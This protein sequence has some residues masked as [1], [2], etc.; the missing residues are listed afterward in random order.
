MKKA[1]FLL[2]TVFLLMFSHALAEDCI[3]NLLDQP[4][5]AYAFEEGA[6]ILEIV[7]PN[8]HGSDACILRMN[9]EVMMI[10]CSTD[11]Q[12]PLLVVPVLRVCSRILYK[13]ISF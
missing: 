2:L 8:V 11:D 6:P 9:G 5:A 13:S 12:S 10:D 1:F 4:D 3:V 7:Y